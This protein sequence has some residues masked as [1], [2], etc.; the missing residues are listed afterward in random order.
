MFRLIGIIGA[1]VR[2]AV[3]G[4]VALVL[5]N[6][7]LR[8]QVAVLKRGR[9][10]PEV[11]LGDRIFWVVLRRLWSDWAEWLHVVR[12]ETVVRW[13]RAG[14]RLFWTWKSRRRSRRPQADH[15]A[16]DL[17]RRL[18]RENNWGAPR[19]HGELLKLG[20]DVSEQTVSRYLPRRPSDPDKVQRWITF[21]RN[22]ASVSAAMDLFVVPTATF[23]LLYGFFVIGHGRRRIFHFNATLH[24]TAEWVVQQLREAFPEDTAPKYLLFD[25]DTIFSAAVVAFVKAMGTEP[26]RSAYR[27][28]WQ[29]PVAERWVGSCRRELLDHIVVFGAYIGYHHAD[30]THL[31]LR[32]DTPAGRAVAPKPSPTAKVVALPRV[33]GLHHRYEWRAAA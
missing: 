14:F 21:L 26:V 16:R 33:G 17:I 20:F 10:R 22:H 11:A 3:K 5:E 19:I 15:E 9:P 25:R 4:R 29:N 8:Q 6:V 1:L 13:H 24:P 31:G 27:S 28:P 32:K 30:R 18:A 12:P 7:A 2:A 23:R